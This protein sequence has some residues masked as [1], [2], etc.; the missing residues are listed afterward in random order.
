MSNKILFV[1]EGEKTEK[2]IVKNLSKHLIDGSTIVCCAFCTDIYKLHKEISDDEDLDT[3]ILLKGKRQNARLLSAYKREDFA[4]IYMFFD[5][6][7]HAPLADDK[8]IDEVLTFFDDETSHGKLFI[9]YPMVEA[10]KHNPSTLNFELLKVDA[11]KNI[12]YKNLVH[13]SSNAIQRDLTSYT[14]DVWIN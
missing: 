12:N 13:L 11:K 8:K 4:E 14:K 6:D 2:Q 3:F 10:L 5:Y 7:G 9:S 1:F